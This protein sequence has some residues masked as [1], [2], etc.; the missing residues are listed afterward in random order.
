[1]SGWHVTTVEYARP[2][3]KDQARFAATAPSFLIRWPSDAVVRLI[4]TEDGVRVDVRLIA[5]Q[6]WPLLHGDDGDIS[7]YLDRIGT[8]IQ[9][10]PGHAGR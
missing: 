8:L 3:F 1:M 5:R 10:K 9:G 2:P 7:A 4:T 6:P